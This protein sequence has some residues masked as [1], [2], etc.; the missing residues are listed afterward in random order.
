MVLSYD[1]RILIKN[2]YEAKG[3][4]AKKLIKEFPQ[5]RWRR[6]TLNDFLK[7]IRENGTIDRKEGSGRPRS[8]RTV[9]NIAEVSE[10]VLSQDNKPQTHRSTRPI[11]RQTGISRST[12]RN[13]IHTDLDL[14]C[15]KRRRA[16]Q[17]TEANFETRRV[18]AQQLLQ[19]FDVPDVDSFSSQM[20]NCL[21]LRFLETRRMIVC[22]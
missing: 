19:K 22:M 21:L 11:S 13:I 1:H 9:E 3:Y 12:V 2:V 20:K 18:R 17:L 8:V 6:S 7:R 5:K 16:Q 10:L 14:N 4:G 15:L